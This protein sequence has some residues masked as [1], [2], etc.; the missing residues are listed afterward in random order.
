MKKLF[1]SFLILA[2]SAF[3]FQLNAQSIESGNIYSS[4]G[5]IIAVYTINHPTC[6]NSS[7]GTIS[8]NLT[9]DTHSIEWVDGSNNT[10]Y[11]QLF[12][13][14]YQ[15]KILMGD[16][17]IDYKVSLNQPDQLI[18]SITQIKNGNTYNLDL[19]VQGG[20]E[21]YSY[22]WS[23]GSESQD[24]SGIVKAGI[25]TVTITDKYNCPLTL[26]TKI[27]RRI[28]PNLDIKN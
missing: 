20:V 7:T 28:K 26:Q 6:F 23:N 16:S 14:S 13:G 21:P 27:N 22:S 2:S 24:L 11:K 4:N 10:T 8:F 3:L 17:H 15:F 25:Y 1:A 9:N 5:E 19:D 18:G 12:A